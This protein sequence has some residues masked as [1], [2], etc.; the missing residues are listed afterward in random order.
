M[1]KQRENFIEKFRLL[2]SQETSEEISW[3]CS[4]SSEYEDN[5]SGKY[6]NISYGKRKKG[7]RK[8]KE[9]RNISNL[10]ITV[11][12]SS[13][14]RNSSLLTQK[15]PILVRKSRSEIKSPILTP[16][17]S[18]VPRFKSNKEVTNSPVIN[19]N[20]DIST[21]N[22]VKSPIILL[23]RES[24]KVSPKV[25]KKLFETDKVTH[26]SENKSESARSTSPIISKTG[27]LDRRK[28]FIQPKESFKIERTKYSNEEQSVL[29]LNNQE[30]EISNKQDLFV[31]T[32]RTKKSNEGLQDPNSNCE[33]KNSKFEISIESSSSDSATNISRTDLVAKVKSYFDNYFSSQASNHSISECETP[34]PKSS[35][36]SEDNENIN[37][38]TQ[39]KSLTPSSKNTHTT[40]SFGSIVGIKQK[41]VKYKKGGLAFRLSAL[42]KKQ[43][44]ST[45]LWQHERFMAANSNFIIPKEEFLAFRIKNVDFNF[46]IHLIEV[47]NK[48]NEPFLIVINSVYVNNNSFEVDDILKVYKPYDIIESNTNCKIVVNVCKFE[49]RKLN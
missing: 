26:S 17:Q 14:E 8:R 2:D 15:S 11:V 23:K 31:I 45:S 48:D 42:L 34:T 12:D 21:R 20:R 49:C 6:I 32:K 36:S 33:Q 28:S 13:D 43:N 5:T 16:L 1:K 30:D 19:N 24:S 10:D 44:A 41:K 47:V 22:I 37:E 4:D 39:V 29:N 9:L 35:K 25:K 7:N 40:T 27:C 46:S 3:S 18:Y 38:I